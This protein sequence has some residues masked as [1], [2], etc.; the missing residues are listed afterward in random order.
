MEKEKNSLIY[1]VKNF[2][3]KGQYTKIKLF[4]SLLVS[5]LVSIAYELTRD[6]FVID[7]VFILTI[8]IM[9]VLIHF[10]IKL[11]KIYNFIYKYRYYLAIVA[12]IIVTLGKY[13]GSSIGVYN[14]LIPSENTEKYY[15]PILGK[16]RVIRGDE[17]SVNT[18]IL[19][20][21]VMDEDNK[22][23]YYNDNLRGTK[24]D[25]FLIVSPAIL[26]ILEI[27]K[28]FNLGYILFGAE[29]GFAIAW[30]GKWIA[31]MLVAFEF[32]MLITNKKKLISLCGMLMIVFS[33]ASQWWGGL[34]EIMLWGLLALLLVDKFLRTD[35]IKI[36]LLC[37]I[38]IFVCAVSYIFLMYPAW[39]V[40]YIYIYIALFISL[41]I[42]NKKYYK[43]RKTDII[44]L[45]LAIV[46]IVLL[47]LRFLTMS[48]EGLQ[49]E[50]GTDYP[51]G[52]FEIGGGG[53]RALFSYVYDFFYP[54]I[55]TDNPCE[56]SGM[57]SFFPIPIII[58]IIVLVK[59]KGME[60]KK[61]MAFL[62]PLLFL[63][64]IFSIYVLV[65]TNKFFA[66]ITLLYF[67]TGVR[68]AVPLGFIQVL[69]IIYLLST[70]NSR[71]KI[72][73]TKF[74]KLIT[75]IVSAIIYYIAIKTSPSNYIGLL[76]SYVCI[77]IL[78]SMVYLLFTM[79]KEKNKKLLIGGLIA[80]SLVAG[81][82]VNPIQKGISVLT[83]K[84]ISKEVQKIVEEDSENNL[85]ATDSTNYYMP[86][87]LLA[88]GAKVINSTNV[89]PNFDLYRTVLTE[90]DYN[91]E[92][93]KYIY[94]R[95]AHVSIE[96][97]ESNN[98]IELMYE[99][100]VKLYMTAEKVKELG[101]KYILTT[102]DIEKFET[103]DVDFEN[104]YSE[105]GLLIYK[106]VY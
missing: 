52:R 23:S 6:I 79:E 66:T 15:T 86:N 33:A 50:M 26:D 13:T 57:L 100:S 90:E 94:N 27:A 30:Y 51:G 8:I 60:K 2:L 20:S 97:T 45:I 69:I 34:N 82:C 28:P 85:W 7:T 44:Y 11:D 35:K 10:I 63:S 55:D 56:Y 101:I 89:Y 12:L 102:R 9:F 22:F 88:N 95:Y 74:I 5:I 42:M 3:K 49:L 47:A 21:Q 61:N 73:P 99:D 76:K 58:A 32:C 48:A 38:G 78:L 75:V 104:I 87:Y 16:Y 1:K 93:I 105:L 71:M 24:T 70:I 25:M 43:F 103:E 96:I 29:K 72:V 39:Q 31:L 98:S 4:I 62:I 18:P 19:I 81:V 68:T 36:K 106:V 59:T 84:P 41:C 17:W 37:T 91:N 64:V 67:S 40:P 46:G 65:P 54:Y 80:M 92:D 77:V 14:E 83:E 53:A